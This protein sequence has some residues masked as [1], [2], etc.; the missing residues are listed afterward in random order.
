MPPRDLSVKRNTSVSLQLTMH[1]RDVQRGSDMNHSGP[2]HV[3][4]NRGSASGCSCV[5]IRSERLLVGYK[6][7]LTPGIRRGHA[8]FQRDCVREAQRLS[9]SR[10]QIVLLC[11]TSTYSSSSQRNSS[12][13]GCSAWHQSEA[14]LLPSRKR[15][16]TGPRK[17]DRAKGTAGST[18][19]PA[20]DL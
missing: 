16:S 18:P 10:I 6:Q 12:R 8:R 5:K 15:P 1:V 4:A 19:S 3:V 14:V 17:G 9:T 7:I 20:L 11:E 2:P 13:V